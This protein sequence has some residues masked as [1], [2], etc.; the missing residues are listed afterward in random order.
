MSDNHLSGVRLTFKVKNS[1]RDRLPE[2]TLNI[3]QYL[4][5]DI[6]GGRTRLCAPWWGSRADSS[7]YGI[8]K[9]R[10]VGQAEVCRASDV[11]QGA[12]KR[13]A[14]DAAGGAVTLTGHRC[15][16]LSLIT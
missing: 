7:V 3:L 9:R 6:G 2:G 13:L 8:E 10:A 1:P 16:L 5:E 15:M 14:M 11:K 4:Y 12:T